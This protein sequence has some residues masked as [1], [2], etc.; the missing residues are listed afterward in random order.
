MAG[1]TT[2]G[3]SFNYGFAGSYA[4][5]P[6]MIIATR[7]NADTTPITIGRPVM[8]AANGVTNITTGFTAAAFAGIAGREVK[9]ALDFTAQSLGVGGVYSP[10]EPVPV[11]QRGSIS[12]ICSVGTPALGGAVYVR[13]VAATGKNIGDIEATADSTNNVLIPNA[14]WG[15]DADAN[16]V[17]ELVLLTRANA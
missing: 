1:G 7:P 6:D 9:S 2:I 13:V 4:R 5:Q 8:N 12:V 15:S 14:Q 16:G 10:N 3:K 17:A 11:F